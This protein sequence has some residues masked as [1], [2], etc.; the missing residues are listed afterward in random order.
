MYELVSVLTWPI[1]STK[2]FVFNSAVIANTVLS[3]QWV[4]PQ[5]DKMIPE[6]ENL[7]WLHVP[8]LQQKH[9]MAVASESGRERHGLRVQVFTAAIRGS[10]TRALITLLYIDLEGQRRVTVCNCIP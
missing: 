6:V 7:D 5:L 9:D 2:S 8:L 1:T 3:T 4:H 10:I